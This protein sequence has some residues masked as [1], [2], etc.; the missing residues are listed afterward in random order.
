MRDSLMP[1]LTKNKELDALREYLEKAGAD[2][3][4][5][6]AI[7]QFASK[8]FDM[9]K[10][11]LKSEN[12]SNSIDLEGSARIIADFWAPMSA[13]SAWLIHKSEKSCHTFFLSFCWVNEPIKQVELSESLKAELIFHIIKT[14]IEKG[15]L[16][17]KKVPSY[18]KNLLYREPKLSINNSDFSFLSGIKLHIPYFTDLDN[19]IGIHDILSQMNKASI[20]SAPNAISTI[21]IHYFNKQDTFNEDDIN[22]VIQALRR[23]DLSDDLLDVV[24][25]FLITKLKNRQAQ[26]PFPKEIDTALTTIGS[27]A[28]SYTVKITESYRE[29]KTLYNIEENLATRYLNFDEILRCVELAYEIDMDEML[30]EQMLINIRRYNRDNNGAIDLLNE[31]NLYNSN[32]SEVESLSESLGNL[33]EACTVHSNDH[34][35][36]SRDKLALAI[37][38]VLKGC[39]P[40]MLLQ[41]IEYKKDPSQFNI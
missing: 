12:A 39:T 5:K 11:L 31:A 3:S 2:G 36:E 15:L 35:K 10:D 34:C 13:L 1:Y 25:N 38:S 26:K 21:N 22:D 9:R 7:I 16:K 37:A 41:V 40:N 32:L 33:S 28:S 17:R 24:S 29:L 8:F 27:A 14:N 19:R 18:F 4:V 23:L 6:K 20:E 30:K